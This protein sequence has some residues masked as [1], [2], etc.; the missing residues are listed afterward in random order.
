MQ[1]VAAEAADAKVAKQLQSEVPQ[2]LEWLQGKLEEAE[3]RSAENK[4][5]QQATADIAQARISDLEA[6]VCIVFS[7]CTTGR[8]CCSFDI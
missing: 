1:C 8:S 6:Q 3:K 5:T 2:K 7:C 4:H